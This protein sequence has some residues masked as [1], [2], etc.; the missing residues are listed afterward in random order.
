MAPQLH[1]SICLPFPLPPQIFTEQLARQIYIFLK[2][3][4]IK[5]YFSQNSLL[6]LKFRS[7]MIVTGMHLNMEKYISWKMNSD[8]FLTQNKSDLAG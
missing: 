6:K 2:P 7:D 3:V 4:L 1:S 8:F 5:L